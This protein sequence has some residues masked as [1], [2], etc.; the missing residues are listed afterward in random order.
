MAL[1][2]H[3]KSSWPTLAAAG[4]L[5]LIALAVP[6]TLGL[7]NHFNRGTTGDTIIPFV[8]GVV[9]ILAFYGFA[10]WAL[11]GRIQVR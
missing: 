3:R 7:M 10:A 11:L 8:I 4:V 1:N 5:G 2:V 9:L 6:C